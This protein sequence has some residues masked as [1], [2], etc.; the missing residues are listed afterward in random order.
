MSM[1]FDFQHGLASRIMCVAG[2]LEQHGNRLLLEP[3]GLSFSSARILLLVAHGVHSPLQL[4]EALRVTKSNISQR[5]ALL[6]EKGLIERTVTAGGDK[7]CRSIALT[8]LGREKAN[9]L[10]SAISLRSLEL[11]H[12]LHPDD[13]ATCER[14]LTA[15]H[16][17]LDTPLNT[18][19]PEL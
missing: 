4:Q 13:V 6:E 16:H 5:L 1:D 2:R 8:A 10:K 14:V 18:K 19:Q 17:L 11:E 7:R 15:I 3:M 12:S 9:A